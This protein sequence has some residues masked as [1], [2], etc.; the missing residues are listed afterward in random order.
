LVG[1]FEKS[2]AADMLPLEFN[3]ELVRRAAADR[4]SLEVTARLVGG[5]EKNGA[6]DI[7]ELEV[8][9][10]LVRRAAADKRRLEFIRPLVGG[11]E[12]SGAA[13][14]AILEFTHVLVHRAA[15]DNTVLEFIGSLVGGSERVA[16]PDN[17]AM[18]FNAPVV[19]RAAADNARLEF[20]CLLVGGSE[21]DA[22]DSAHLEFTDGLVH[23]AAADTG[24]MEIKPGLVGGFDMHHPGRRRCDL[25][26]GPYY[27]W[28]DFSWNLRRRPSRPTRGSP[29]TAPSL[30]HRLAS[31]LD[32]LACASNCLF[33]HT[34]LGCNG[35]IGLL[36]MA[37]QGDDGAVCR[38]DRGTR[39]PTMGPDI[40]RAAGARAPHLSTAFCAAQHATPVH[41]APEQLLHAFRREGQVLT[42][43]VRP[44]AFVGLEIIGPERFIALAKDGN[45]DGSRD[46]PAGAL[47]ADQVRD[48]LR[49]RN[50][51]IWRR[52]AG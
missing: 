46:L 43:E 36:R 15:A 1:G 19:R 44:R 22:A 18:E 3:D 50:M 39:G 11:F 37:G 26:T 24:V 49:N 42:D 10:E 51:R 7:V 14:N 9:R 52:L 34:Y 4:R 40:R 30:R 28:A 29:S 17:V 16:R 20:M 12:K 38:E 31:V 41:H 25:S 21:S 6:T 33:R 23:R 47:E 45:C 5:F 13:D 8:I 32:L 27:L 48:D 35:A 2:G